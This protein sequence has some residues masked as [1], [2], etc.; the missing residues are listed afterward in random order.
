MAWLSTQG[1]RMTSAI[2][3]SRAASCFRL[4]LFI[5]L[6]LSF[7]DDSER[8]RELA[9]RRVADISGDARLRELLARACSKA[10][11]EEYQRLVGG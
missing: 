3:Y 2:E 11:A 8:V 10:A 1:K 7:Y 9:R 6:L 4:L 5:A